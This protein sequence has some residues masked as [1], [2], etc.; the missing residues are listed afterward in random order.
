MADSWDEVSL[1]APMST[2]VPRHPSETADPEG[3]AHLPLVADGES[4]PEILTDR[5]RSS[6][7]IVA[8][9]ADFRDSTLS[10]RYQPTLVAPDDLN[11]LADEVGALFAQR[12]TYCERRHSAGSCEECALRLGRVP[13][14]A[15]S[16]FDV[17]TDSR[18]VGLARRPIPPDSAELRRPL[19][20]AKP[21]GATLSASPERC[22]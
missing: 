7:G 21:W 18:R 15:A 10:V 17:T 8:I 13:D 20:V 19:T 11:A 12:V 1:V 3:A 5:L 14:A 2:P 16:E 9:E 6:P 4:C 22:W